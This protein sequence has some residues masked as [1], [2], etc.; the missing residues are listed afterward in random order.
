M[1]LKKP[2]SRDLDFSSLRE[3]VRIFQAAQQELVRLEQT[4]LVMVD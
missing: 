3:Y 1:P 4:R 2:P